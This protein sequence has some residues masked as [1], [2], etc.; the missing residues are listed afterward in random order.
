MLVAGTRGAG[1][2]SFLSSI[3]IEVMRKFRIITIEDTL[4]QPVTYLRN[5]GYNILPMKVRSAIVGARSE[6]SAPEGIR[7]SLRLGDS[8]L[9]IGE[10]RSKEAVALY[11]AM[12]IGAL[13]NV[14]A[15]TIHGDSAYGVFDR[16]VNDL[17]VPRTSFKATDIIII[18]NKLRSPDMLSEYRRVVQIAEV[19]KHWEDDPLREGGFMNL[20]EYN[21]KSDMLEP[22]KELLE[23]DTEVIKSIAGKVRE[24]AGN[25]DRVWEN[26]LL[27][28]KIKNMLVEYAK[29]SKDDSILESDFVVVANDQ[30]HDI[31]NKLREETGY[32]ET[33]DVLYQF[34]NWLKL[35]LRGKEGK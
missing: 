5:I 10:V 33:K 25:W 19:R 32:P 3:M 22:T 35:K 18:C 16:V 1:K 21:A 4:E 26:I 30:F 14:V 34:E 20:M 17:G 23:G 2:T 9:F 8:C 31:Y 29:K 15:G 27:R 12:R 6:M 13:A 7:T 11:E 28:S 24:W